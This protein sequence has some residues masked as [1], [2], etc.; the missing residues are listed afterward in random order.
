M[1][2]TAML[3]PGNRSDQVAAPALARSTSGGVLLADEGYRGGDLFDWFYEEAQMLRV[4]PSDGSTD[5]HSTI[6]RARQQAE[7]SFSGL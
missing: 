4:M 2:I 7:S 1:V 3:L 6:S 5:G